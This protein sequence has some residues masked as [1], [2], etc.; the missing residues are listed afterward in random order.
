LAKLSAIRG[1]LTVITENEKVALFDLCVHIARVIEIIHIGL[2]DGESVHEELTGTDL[3]LI[4]RNSDDALDVIK[5]RI[6]GVPQDDDVSTLYCAEH[7]AE[8]I[9]KDPVSVLDP[10]AHGLA[11][12]HREVEE[13]QPSHQERD[14]ELERGD[15]G[16][17][18]AK[19]SGRIHRRERR[20]R[21]GCRERDRP[22]LHLK[23]PVA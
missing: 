22:C 20:E 15:R 8:A 12:H 19:S 9:N 14:N 18:H 13:E 21:C 17:D 6:Q 7:I 5:T 3:N 10:W 16:V 2:I 11:A 4:S 1:A 23:D